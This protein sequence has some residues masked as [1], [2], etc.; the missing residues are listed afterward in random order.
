[1]NALRVLNVYK[2]EGMWVFDDPAVG[3]DREP[4]VAGVPEILDQLRAEHDVTGEKF[5]IVF[6]PTP[7]PGP[8]LSG[9]ARRTAATGTAPLSMG[10]LSP[11]GSA[12]RC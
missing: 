5:N 4:F 6:S 8:R 9:S 2:Y 3:L 10:K 12:Q 7:F 1:L 11:A